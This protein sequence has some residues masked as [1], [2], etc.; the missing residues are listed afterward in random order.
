MKRPGHFLDRRRFLGTLGAGAAGAAISRLGL[1][2][3]GGEKDRRPNIV[4]IMADD[5]G[6]E[7]LGSYGGT[8]YKT[9]H[10]DALAASGVRFENCYST[11]ICSPSRAQVMTGRYPFRTGWTRLINGKPEA[12]EFL[13]PDERTFGHVLKDAGYATALAG[14]WQ[15]CQF[16]R[17]PDHAKQCGFDEHCCWTWRIKGVQQ[18]RYW[19]PAIWQD[20][21][22]RKDTGGKYGPDLFCD[23]LIDFMTRNRNR[24]FFAYY[25]MV[26]V[27]GPF[28]PTPAGAGGSKGTKGKRG[29]VENFASMV[30]YM[31]KLVGR[32]LAA[33]ERLGIRQNTLFV[34]TG[35]NGTPRQVTSKLGDRPINGGKGRMSE[36]GTRVPLIANWKGAAPPGRVLEDL[37]DFSDMMPTFAELAGARLPK[38][39]EI[40]GRSF[41]PQLRGRRGNP[42]QWAYVQLGGGRFVRDRRWRLD[43]RGRLYD[44]QDRYG[45]RQVDTRTTA[46]AEAKAAYNKLK[47]ALGALQGRSR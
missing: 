38:G 3:E 18:P 1:S 46:D 35:D 17:H 37:V 47:A 39:V 15:L 41:A 32:L 36:A 16:N 11:P 26:L 10:L 13:S 6:A 43:E 4:F 44:M 21:R 29:G 20:G 8:S 30:A 42:R 27:H 33:A 31:D 2:A 5:L 24:P 12:D 9:P 40:D 23:F 25:P 19:S 14:K 7:C 28:L 45:A 22:R 34:F